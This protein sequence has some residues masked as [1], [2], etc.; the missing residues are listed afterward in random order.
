MDAVSSVNGG[1]GVYALQKAMES[2]E[3][4]I[5]KVSEDIANENIDTDAVA[6]MVGLGQNLDITA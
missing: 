2:Q 3:D 5:A 1:A 6:Q 4:I